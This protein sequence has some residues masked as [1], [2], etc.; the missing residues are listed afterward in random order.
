MNR[1]PTTQ[2]ITWLIDLSRN[3][4]LNLDPPYQRRSVWTRKDKQFF[5][6]TILRNY[7][8]PAV[9]L[10]K[11]I[12]ENGLSTY[13]VVDG[14]Q[15]IQ[16][17]LEFVSDKLRAAKEFGDLRIDNK[18][19]S[20]IQKV[21]ELMQSFWNYQITV[22]MIDVSDNGV[23]NNVFDRLNRN[24]R[25]L[26][27]QEMRHARFDGWLINYAENEA[28]EKAWVTL[29]IATKARAKRMSDIQF[30]SELLLVVLDRRIVGFDQDYIDEGYARFD[31]L[32]DVGGDFDVE[33]FAERVALLKNFMLRLEDEYSLVSK[34]AKQ[35]GQFYSLWGALAL[36]D[37]LPP[38]GD[39]AEKYAA[40][41]DKV[42]ELNEQGDI[43]S[44]I[45]NKPEGEYAQALVYLTNLKGASTEPAQR[46]ARHNVISALINQ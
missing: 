2:D 30:I 39:F 1:R 5:L 24:S 35:A 31:D 46:L 6:D 11:E 28:S 40:L 43:D 10:H 9:F 15:R 42:S 26:M 33:A 16:T 32:D 44:F 8:S 36:S 38:V 22:E 23:V 45:R 41:M 12:T 27:R 37:A 25:K 14:K 29:S 17:I 4:K 18:K 3:G 19:W 7:P 13:H 20:E 34:Y 21:D